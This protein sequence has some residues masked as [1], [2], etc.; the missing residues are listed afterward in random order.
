MILICAIMLGRMLASAGKS[1]STLIVRL[2]AV[3][4]AGC[5]IDPGAKLPADIREIDTYLVAGLYFACISFRNIGNYLS[6]SCRSPRG[7]RIRGAGACIIAQLND[8][9]IYCA[10]DGRND[11]G[12]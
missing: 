12:L 10:V 7:S 9:C 3:D 6:G 8:H 11:P 2:S 5:E 4:G 1:T